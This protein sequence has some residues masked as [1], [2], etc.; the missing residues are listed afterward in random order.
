MHLAPPTT[1]APRAEC[2]RFEWQCSR[3][4]ECI[5]LRSR[6]DGQIDCRDRSDELDCPVACRAGEF[7]CGSGE[8]ISESRK[9]DRHY[10]CRDGSDE[11]DCCKF[12]H[13]PCR[14]MKEIFIQTSH[15]YFVAKVLF[16]ILSFY[17]LRKHFY[18]L[19]TCNH[20]NRGTKT[21]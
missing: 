17:Y 1:E 16:I 14:F 4:S 11:T 3:S 5:S 20:N 13:R 18:A 8:C 21:R 19:S 9:C 12:Y 15:K 2:N 7:H 6:C 10:D